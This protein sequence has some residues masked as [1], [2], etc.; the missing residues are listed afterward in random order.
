MVPSPFDPEIRFIIGSA[1]HM[2]AFPKG[3]QAGLFLFTGRGGIGTPGCKGA[4]LGQ[5][6]GVRHQAGNG[7]ELCL[8]VV[9]I[10]QGVEQALGL[11]M[12]GMVEYLLQSALFD[13]PAGIHD[14]HLVADLGH[15]AQIMGDHDHCHVVLFPQVAH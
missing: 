9:D 6:G 1:Q 10:G 15:D 11:G 4:A 7:L 12:L 5:V 14:G 8:A 3:A 2:V 13:D